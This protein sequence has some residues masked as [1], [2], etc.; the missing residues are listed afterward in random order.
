MLKKQKNSL[1]Y[2]GKGGKIFKRMYITDMRSHR[3]K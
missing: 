3:L 2:Q 1:T